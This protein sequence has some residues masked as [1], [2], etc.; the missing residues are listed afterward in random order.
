MKIRNSKINSK[1]EWK[2]IQK[3]VSR[4]SFNN[5]GILSRHSLKTPRALSGIKLVSHSVSSTKNS[6]LRKYFQSSSN[7]LIFHLLSGNWTCIVSKRWGIVLINFN[8]FISFLGKITSIC[9]IIQITAYWN[10]E[11]SHFYWYWIWE[12]INENIRSKFSWPFWWEI[13]FNKL[14]DCENWANNSKN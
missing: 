3:T 5:S 14:S 4:F 2:G 1:E 9:Y 6:F 8:G 11:E 7:I 10:Q 13:N 12:R